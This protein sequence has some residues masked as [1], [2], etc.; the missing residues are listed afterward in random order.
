MIPFGLLSITEREKKQKG[1]LNPGEG[2]WLG[3]QFVFPSFHNQIPQPLPPQSP[4][5]PGQQPQQAEPPPEPGR[6]ILASL[7]FVGTGAQTEGFGPT[8]PAPGLSP[9]SGLPSPSQAVNQQEPTA[10]PHG[11]PGLPSLPGL[12]ATE[13]PNT[14]KNDLIAEVKDFMSKTAPQAVM[15]DEEDLAMI[16]RQEAAEAEAAAAAGMGGADPAGPA[17]AGDHQGASN[18]GEAPGGIGGAG[19]APY[20]KGGMIPNRGSPALEDVNIRAK[21]T[22]FVLKPEASR[23]Y[24]KGILGAL[25]AMKIP[26][27]KLKGILGDL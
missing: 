8:A 19:D 16:D 12:P 7:P 18:P 25:N 4:L 24:G 22:E 15:A 23:Y 27:A 13:P 11:I 14:M 21:E 5:A 2:Y 3:N 17:G 26:K 20:H 6:G 10:Q 9:A 1:P